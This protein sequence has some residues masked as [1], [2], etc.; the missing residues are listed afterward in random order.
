MDTAKSVAD[1]PVKVVVIFM[2]TL[3][4]AELL[5]QMLPFSYELIVFPTS[6]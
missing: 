1:I 3:T 6:I 2:N 5:R 4:E